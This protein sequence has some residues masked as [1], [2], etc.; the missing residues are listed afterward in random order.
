MTQFPDHF[1]GHSTDYASFRPGYPDALFAWLASIAPTTTLVWDCATGSGQ[2]AIG[3]ARHF[4]QVIATDASAQQIA[5]AAHAPNVA[6]RVASAEACGLDDAAVDLVTVAQA[7]HWFR[8]EAFYAEAR[9][10][11]RPDGVL[12]VWTYGLAT[13]EP[14]V[15]EIVRYLY[16]DV[17]GPYWD[18]ERKLVDG[19]YRELEFPFEEIK[20]PHFDMMAAWSLDH[21]LGYLRTWSAV[22]RYQREQGKDPVDAA[23]PALLRAWGARDDARTV[24]WPL[25]LRVGRRQ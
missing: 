15:D 9:R 1:S 19:G 21:L 11:L 8:R 13:V 24:R 2:A 18:F 17:V 20:A 22:K 4:E 25:F 16:G 23:A 6:Y 3:L 10:V 5:K 14:E 12:A 7:V